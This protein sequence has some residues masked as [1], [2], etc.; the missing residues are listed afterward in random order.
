MKPTLG[1]LILARDVITDAA[2]KEMSAIRIFDTLFILKGQNSLVYTLSVLGRLYLNIGG[3]VPN[4]QI[5]MK[6]FDPTGIEMR[7]ELLTASNVN[8]EF[9]LNLNCKFWL[10]LF[11]LEG[12]YSIEISVSTDG[13]NFIDLQSPMYF[14]VKKLT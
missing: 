12:R 10:I 3:M 1:Y 5:R 11:Q 9:G 2:S 7:T 14:Q 13:I 4:V 8:T 6:L